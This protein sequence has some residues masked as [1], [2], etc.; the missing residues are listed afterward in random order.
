M[1]RVLTAANPAEAHL[2]RGFLEARGIR[3]VVQGES[4]WAMRGK[5]PVT[6][7]TL[8]SVWVA[9]EDA[10]RAGTL[11]AERR[12]SAA[13]THCGACGYDLTGLPEPRCPECGMSFHRPESWVCPDCDE[14]IEAQFAVCWKCAGAT[15]TAPD[16]DRR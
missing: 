15:D 10:E 4:L 6:T 8:P 2:I 7:D 3:A 1:I 11:I 12:G 13:P 14:V 16:H 9:N 5:L